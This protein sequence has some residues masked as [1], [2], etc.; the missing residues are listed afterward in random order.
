MDTNDTVKITVLLPRKDNEGKC[1]KEEGKKILREVAAHYGGFT[2]DGVNGAYMMENGKIA[3]D[4]STRFFVISSRCRI[5]GFLKMAKRWARLLRQ[6]SLYVEISQP[7]LVLFVEPDRL[8]LPKTPSSSL[9][10]PSPI[11]SP[12]FYNVWN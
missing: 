8:P 6:E 3:H 1:L 5:P 4:R 10:A 12:C 2:T 7:E 9:V 11:P